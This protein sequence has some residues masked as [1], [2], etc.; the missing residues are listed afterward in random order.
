MCGLVGVA[1]DINKTEKDVFRFLLELDTR[2]GPHSTGVLTVSQ[3]GNEHIIKKI[4]TPWELYQYKQ[5]DALIAVAS[6]VLMG[7]NRWATRGKINNA[8]AHPF[9]YGD[10]IGAHNGTLRGQFRLEDYREFDVDS[11]NIFYHL[12]KKGEKDLFAHLDGAFALSWWNKKEQTLKLVRNSERPLHYAFN[13]ENTT[14]FWASEAWMIDA[15]CRIHSIKR[16]KIKSLTEERLYTFSIPIGFTMKTEPVKLKQRKLEVF[17]PEPKKYMMPAKTSTG[18][19]GQTNKP[20]TLPAT[21]HGGNDNGKKS[22]SLDLSSWIGIRSEFFIDT[23]G[24]AGGRY[25]VEGVSLDALDVAIRIYGL[26]SDSKLAS[27]L[28][29]DDGNEYISC[30]P[31]YMCNNVK[32]DERYMVAQAGTVQFH[33]W[34]QLKDLDKKK[35]D[36]DDILDYYGDPLSDEQYYV[37]TKKG[38]AWCGDS[39]SLSD[40]GDIV[41]IDRHEFICKVC[42]HEDAVQE[43]LPKDILLGG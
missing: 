37:N 20:K 25:Y 4:G 33:E 41:W 14:L 8:C 43:Y 2:R 42:K 26:S 38:C 22:L 12:N 15:A 28:M 3:A 31:S 18:T 6:N 17:K 21:S 24:E 27:R 32:D 36:K 10:I 19:T 7:H 16:S 5:W 29:N 30:V 39:S 35:D 13:E 23:D 34:P 1:G 40:A 9:E 11:E